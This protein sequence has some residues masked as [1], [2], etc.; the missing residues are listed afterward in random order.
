MTGI[1]LVSIIVPVYGVEAYLSECVD[2]LL[3]QTYQNLEIILIDDSSPDSSAAICDRY[4][5]KD[6]R[7]NVIHKK[8]GGAASARN[9]GLD[10]ANG[11]CICFVDAD[12]VVEKEYVEHLLTALTDADADIA[13]CGYYDLTRSQRRIVRCQKPGTYSQVEYLACFLEDWSCSLLW[14]KIYRREVIGKLRMT[15]GHKID[16]EFFTY[17]V[18]MDSKKIVVTEP[19]L[20]GYRMRASSV[21]H[22][23]D[24]E[25][26]LL[27]KIEFLRVRY[28]DIAQRYPILEPAYFQ[29]AVDTMT[30]YWRASYRLSAA[31]AEIQKWVSKRIGKL[32]RSNM[33]VKRRLSYYY[34]LCWKKP[35]AL[36]VA[37]EVQANLDDYFD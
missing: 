14:N 28:N 3:A 7:I 23:S 26:L 34:Q 32:L 12:D 20:Y 31:Q 33:P 2:S 6:T 27:D 21:M 17:R 35:K 13:V 19:P 1:K 9:A 11:D 25:R 18:V 15:E 22:G 24:R 4:A 10:M 30:R 5:Q 29:D 36:P 37:S 16:D 8:N